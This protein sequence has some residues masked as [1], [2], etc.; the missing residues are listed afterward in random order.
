[1][2]LLAVSHVNP[3]QDGVHHLL[4]LISDLGGQLQGIGKDFNKGNELVMLHKTI[5]VVSL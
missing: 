5:A 2:I 4:I 1:M 3:V